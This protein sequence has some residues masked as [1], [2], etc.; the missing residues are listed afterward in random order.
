MGTY[1]NLFE[2]EVT[3]LETD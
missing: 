2:Y 3:D 1:R